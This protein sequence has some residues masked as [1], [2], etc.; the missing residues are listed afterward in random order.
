MD[1]GT[2]KV[3]SEERDRVPHHLIDVVDPDQNFTAADFARL[4]DEAAASISRRGKLPLVVGGTGLY[5]RALLDGLVDVPPADP[6]LRRT[7]LETEEREGEGALHRRLREADPEMAE[8]LF[9]RDLVRIVRALE[10][11]HLTGSPLSRLQAEQSGATAFQVLFLGL[12][13]GRDE[14]YRRIN[15]RVQTMVAE[16]LLQEVRQLLER[17]YSPESKALRT[18]G[19]EESIAHLRGEISLDEMIGRIQLNSRRYAKRQLTWF[20]KEKSM[21]W[22]DSS[23]EHDKIHALIGNF[24]NDQR[25]GHG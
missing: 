8:R 16:G 7:L 20:R 5:F 10:V 6:L 9:P 13:P 1:I 22:V 15:L 11:F 24:M 12:S 17:G 3:T 18:I 19:Y 14:L 25:S 23:E 4:G 2:A 21:I